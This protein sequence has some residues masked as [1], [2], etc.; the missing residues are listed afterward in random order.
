MKFPSKS[1]SQ[2]RNGTRG[3]LVR[4]KTTRKK[5]PHFDYLTAP[6]KLVTSARLFLHLQQ[7][8]E[9]TRELLQT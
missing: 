8:P 5:W 2:V 7:V 1:A 4:P 3:V 9:N 6:K